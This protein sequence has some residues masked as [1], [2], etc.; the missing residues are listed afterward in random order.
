MEGSV[1]STQTPAATSTLHPHVTDALQST[2]AV[3]TS[4]SVSQME[5]AFE[6]GAKKPN[7]TYSRALS[8]NTREKST[9][10]GV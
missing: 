9:M 6:N 1:A 5:N 4:A 8:R 3:S 7:M 2:A 10:A